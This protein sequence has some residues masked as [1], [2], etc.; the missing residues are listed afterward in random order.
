[1]YSLTVNI[2]EMVTGKKNIITAFK[3]KVIYKLSIGT[4]TFNQDHF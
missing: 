2:L 4:L 3:Q 1:M